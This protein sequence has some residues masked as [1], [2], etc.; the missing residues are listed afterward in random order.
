[1]KFGFEIVEVI[2]GERCSIYT[3]RKEGESETELD[4]FLGS[5]EVGEHSEALQFIANRISN[6]IPDKGAQQRFFEYESNAT[7]AVMKL[8]HSQL[9]C[10]CLRFGKLMVIMGNGGVKPTGIR[11]TQEKEG[12]QH[13]VDTLIY[14]E[15]RITEAQREGKFSF[16]NDNG[17]ITEDSKQTFEPL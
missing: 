2:L 17:S 16:Y 9:R 15:Q 3:I 12:L 13:A 7:N 4:K 14:V 8:K 10:Y 1:V 11:R 5:E 6:I